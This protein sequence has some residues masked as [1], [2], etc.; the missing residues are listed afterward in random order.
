VRRVVADTHALVWF[1]AGDLR[2]L[3]RRARHL[4]RTADGIGL[5]IVVSTISLWE[6]ALLHDERRLALP[7]GFTAW[8]DALDSHQGFRI[9]PITR[10]DV[11]AARTLAHLRD[12]HDRLIAGTAV[13]LGVALLTVDDR[14]AASGRVKVLWD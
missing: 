13:R 10:A 2:R 1:L 14:I 9:E 6:I 5:E 8:C 12:P 3:G 11:E 4:L 7:Q